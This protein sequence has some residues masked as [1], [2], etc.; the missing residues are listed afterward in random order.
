MKSAIE[1][2]YGNLL[3]LLEEQILEAENKG[4][5]HID[6]TLCNH[7]VED[8]LRSLGYKTKE[9]RYET[10]DNVWGYHGRDSGDGTVK[11]RISW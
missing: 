8:H 7:A 3:R 1:V 5:D 4:D 9:I 6:V 2:K 11:L 10:V